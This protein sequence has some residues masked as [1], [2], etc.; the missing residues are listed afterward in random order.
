MPEYSETYDFTSSL[1]K[2]GFRAKHPYTNRVG[3]FY[4]KEIEAQRR[5]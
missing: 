5:K 1:G 2:E 4:L 3:G